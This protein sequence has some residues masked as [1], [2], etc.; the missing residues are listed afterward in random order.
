METVQDAEACVKHLRENR[1]GRATFIGLDKMVVHKA[2][3]L[4][5]FKCPPG[6]KRLFDLVTVKDEKIND[7]LY[8]AL[9]N[10]LVANDIKEGTNIAFNSG[11]GNFRVVTLKGELIEISGV[12]SGGG[13][14]KQGAMGNKIVEE[15][16]DE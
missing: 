7:A 2:E 15:F 6:A 1:I 5:P 10:T 11:L 12:M 9:K 13:R 4:K 3:R 8:F 16:S 14:P